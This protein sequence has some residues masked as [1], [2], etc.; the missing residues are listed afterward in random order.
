MARRLAV[1]ALSLLWAAGLAGGM[2]YML[3][4]EK[5]PGAS[6]NA[7]AHW[8]KTMPEFGRPELPTLVVALH[9][10]CSCSQASL[11][12]L[13]KASQDFGTPYNALL[14]INQP[15][16]LQ[17]AAGEQP[18]AGEAGAELARGWRDN[19][20]YREVAGV[21]HASVKADP[22]GSFAREFG[23][24]T[25]GEVLLYSAANR[26]GVRNLLYAG[27]VTGGRGMTGENAGVDALTRAFHEQHWLGGLPV[28][29]CK[30]TSFRTEAAAN[31]MPLPIVKQEVTR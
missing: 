11:T 27:G 15:A 14:L 20:L 3:H 22:G 6:A 10:R 17:T 25:S 21:L 5:T 2:A 24:E 1:T 31:R 23:A 30:L 19:A 29:G 7:P 26:Q 16:E 13:Q 4:Y 9:P 18:E 8:P 28:F 12:E